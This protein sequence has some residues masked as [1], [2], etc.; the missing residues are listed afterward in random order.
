M[1]DITPLYQKGADITGAAT[2]AV[3]GGRFVKVS[4]AKV[5]GKPVP[6]A[7]AD[8]AGPALG[9]SHGDATN[10]GDT[11]T[12]LKGTHVVPVQCSAAITAGARVEVATGGKAAPLAS[13]I[14]AGLAL[15]TT[16]AADQFVYVDIS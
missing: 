6:I 13:G 5:D 3:V 2:A 14:P 15:S 1:P 7:H 10:I 8:A 12:V 16:T 11:V 9:V 4:A